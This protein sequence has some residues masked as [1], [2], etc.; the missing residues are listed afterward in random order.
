MSFVTKQLLL[1]TGTPPQPAHRF[2]LCV[3]CNKDKPPEGGINMSPT[4][5]ICA[6]CW[7]AKATRRKT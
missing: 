1:N 2:K 5:W 6:A 4:R 7:V 3:K